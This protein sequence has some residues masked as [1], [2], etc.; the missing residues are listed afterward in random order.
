M[1]NIVVTFFVLSLMDL[2]GDRELQMDCKEKILS[3]DYADGVVDFPIE[4]VIGEG[5]DACY[6]KLDD[7]FYTAYQ[8][9]SFTMD[10]PGS[11]LQYQYTPKIYGL[12]ETSIPGAGRNVIFDPSALVDSGIRQLQGQP[13]NLTGA[14]TI[15]GI[16]DT[17]IEY[18]NAAFVDAYGGS[19]ILAIWDQTIQDGPPPEGLLFGTEYTREDINRA[20]A[21]ENPQET[22]KTNDPLRHGTVMAG[23]AAGSV[24]NGGS[25][26]IGAAPEADIVIVKLKEC[27]TYLREYYFLPEGIPAYEESDIMLGI[28]Y[29]NRFAMEFKRPVIFCLGI[30]TNMGDHAGNSILGRYLNRVAGFRSRVMVVCGGNEGS[31]GHHFTWTFPQGEDAVEYRDVEVRV[32]ENEAGFML[33]FWGNAADVF[34]ISVRTPGGETVPPIR[35]GVEQRNTYEFVFER[36]VMTVQSVLV[37]PGSG[38]QFILFR[39]SVPTPGIWT[40]R[41]TTVG[42]VYNGTFHMW[43]PITQFLR[44]STY[45]LEASPD[46][47]ITEPGM[48]E[49][50]ITVSNYNHV[51]DS[52]YLESGRGFARTGSIRPDFAAPG[53]NVPTLYGN[54][55]GS[56]LAAAISAGGA[57]Q[58]MQWAVVEGNSPLAET[59]E[60]KNYFIK[61]AK[62]MP[63]LDYPNREWG[64]GALNVL[65]AF[66][67]I[68]GE[69]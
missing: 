30:G 45:F 39:L 16:I 10:L 44:S 69:I 5:D 49:N 19:R 23:L 26:Y 2:D 65:G 24:V 12:M 52:F 67:K 29:V 35:L 14:G 36:T 38:E 22:V 9:R 15:V 61:G 48:T 31:A 32:G 11:T 40:F 56:S 59:E 25:T 68:R 21:A 7:R 18:T 13:L 64:Y 17:G 50:V 60:V 63:G 6:I 41:V 4:R 28:S 43:L 54:R 42:E 66:E 53:V 57:A 46:T 47:T 34:N 55:T 51:N 3:D 58:F 1:H 62:R 20:L 8:N 33:E 27:K 37:E